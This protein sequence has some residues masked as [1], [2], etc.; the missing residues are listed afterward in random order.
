MWQQWPFISASG[1]CPELDAMMWTLPRLT[2]HS[3]IL[4]TCS[5]APITI[6]K[7]NLQFGASN[8]FHKTMNKI[9]E[10]SRELLYNNSTRWW[11]PITNDYTSDTLTNIL[12]A[13]EMVLLEHFIG[14]TWYTF[15]WSQQWKKSSDHDF[16]SF[17]ST[18]YTRI[19][20]DI[21]L[22]ILTLYK[23]SKVW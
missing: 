23:K 14:C 3:F 19:L 2:G 22:F 9:T 15:S 10:C 5:A 20:L 18:M 16:L 4:I 11:F 21:F 8:C 13:K 7:H 17:H 6:T 12:S 1:H